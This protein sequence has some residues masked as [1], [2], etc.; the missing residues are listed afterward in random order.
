MS[1]EEQINKL[2]ERI[3]KIEERMSDQY[4]ILS[5][6]NEELK[7]INRGIY[8][9]KDNQT[10]GLIDRQRIDEKRL[11]ELEDRVKNIEKN[12]NEKVAGIEGNIKQE[13]IKK[14]TTQELLKKIKEWGVVIIIGFLILKDIIGVDSLLEVFLK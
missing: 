1:T 4:D 2:E 11:L 7:R 13:D 12:I 14:T 8:G 6:M 9:D 5:S 3:E 10:D